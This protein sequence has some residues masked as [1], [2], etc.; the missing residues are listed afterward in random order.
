M[1]PDTRETGVVVS[2]GGRGFGFIQP[3]KGGADVFTHATHLAGGRRA[4]VPG[5]RVEFTRAGWGGRI[6]AVNVVPLD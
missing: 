5:Q 4:L 6:A 3:D 2:W 1:P